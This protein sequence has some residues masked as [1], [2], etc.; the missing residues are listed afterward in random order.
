MNKMSTIPSHCEVTIRR[1]NGEISTIR[2][3][4]IT[5][6]IPKLWE[7][8]KEAMKMAGRGECIS[9]KNVTKQVPA[10][11]PTQ[12]ELE[13]EQYERERDAIYHMAAGGER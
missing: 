7:Q 5:T 9:Y 11:M 3:P 8:M 6:M 1:P 4:K 13:L 12:A 10:I 2:H